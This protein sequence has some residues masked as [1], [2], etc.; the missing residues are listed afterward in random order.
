MYLIQDDY[1]YSLSIC[2]NSGGLHAGHGALRPE[3]VLKNHNYVVR[4]L[5]LS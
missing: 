2:I 4:E 5:E 1:S 3:N